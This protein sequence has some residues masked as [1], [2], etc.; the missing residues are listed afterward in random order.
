MYAWA[1]LHGPVAC[2]E[3][4]YKRKKRSNW[5]SARYSLL[6]LNLN[7]VAEKANNYVSL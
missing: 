2:V 3:D 7:Q 1:S 5:Y 4:E 6:V